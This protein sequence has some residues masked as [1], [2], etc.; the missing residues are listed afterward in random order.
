MNETEI[1]LK[2]WNARGRIEF[3]NKLVRLSKNVFNRKLIL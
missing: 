3:E 2:L 1:D